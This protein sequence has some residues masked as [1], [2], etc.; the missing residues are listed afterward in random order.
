MI[1]MEDRG[2]RSDVRIVGFAR[3]YTMVLDCIKQNFDISQIS[4][5]FGFVRA[6][7][8]TGVSMGDRQSDHLPRSTTDMLQPL[9]S[10]ASRWLYSSWPLHQELY[11]IACSHCG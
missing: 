8:K 6:H 11:I 5:W 1:E 10:A 4:N 7:L 3:G 9:L 2:R